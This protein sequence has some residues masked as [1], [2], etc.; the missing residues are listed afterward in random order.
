MLFNTS[1]YVPFCH[2]CTG[3]VRYSQLSDEQ[4]ESLLAGDKSYDDLVTRSDQT[5]HKQ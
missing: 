4:F 3:C 2:T 1:I 5:E